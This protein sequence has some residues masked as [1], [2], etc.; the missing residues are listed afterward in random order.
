MANKTVLIA[1]SDGFQGYGDFIFGLKLAKQ[2]D[3]R[4]RAQG[5]VEVDIKLISQDS[6][7]DKVMALGG[8]KEFAVDVI[9]PAEL[10][11]Q[12]AAAKVGVASVIEG[13]VFSK[14]LM[15]QIDD[16]LS[17]CQ[18]VP[19][20]LFTEYARNPTRPAVPHCQRLKHMRYH[21]CVKAGM[22]HMKGEQGLMIE[23][24]DLEAKRDD[25]CMDA[26]D[27]KMRACLISKQA[28]PSDY[29]ASTDLWF[30]YSHDH[31]VRTND[32]MTAAEKYLHLQQAFQPSDA[33]HQDVVMVGKDA[34][35]KMAAIKKLVPMLKDRGFD[36]IAFVNVD[37]KHE[38][39]LHEG[40]GSGS[41]YRVLYS[42]SLSHQTMLALLDLSKD[43]V[44]VT[45][46]QSF[47]EAVS[48][49]KTV[50]YE[51]FNHKKSLN[52]CYRL[53]L[54]ELIE[55]CH[56]SRK[57]DLKLVVDTLLQPCD[58]ESI[59]A[60]SKLLT[61]S[62]RRD[63]RRLNEL[64][65]QQQQSICD[66]MSRYTINP[67]RTV[68]CVK[69]EAGDSALM[70]AIKTNDIDLAM[71]L[72]AQRSTDLRARNVVGDCAFDVALKAGHDQLAISIIKRLQSDVLLLKHPAR[73]Q[74]VLF[75]AIH[76]GRSD[77][78]VAL[79]QICR[80]IASIRNS[81]GHSVRQ[82]AETAGMFDVV[83]AIVGR[84]AS[85]HARIVHALVKKP[86]TTLFKQHKTMDAKAGSN[87]ANAD[88]ST[89][90]LKAA[91]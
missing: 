26:I 2:L 31:A 86:A 63:L 88:Y 28:S 73:Q 17:G 51:C 78:A 79:I 1:V 66:V 81:D 22:E 69:Q 41:C 56:F 82:V 3:A 46:D 84:R 91:H 38:T 29:F 15:S 80:V 25:R 23:S 24:V 34:D 47:S 18:R 16:A 19:L 42:A 50:F 71:T 60:L 13:P 40:S 87:K 89:H 36:R 4:Y 72:I 35:E 77:V 59:A 55:S 9:T 53:R 65:L 7:R 67:L 44:G 43:L 33:K 32:S 75:D 54:H 48:R 45:G 83:N 21:A 14:E 5:L 68:D 12:V 58:A 37:S 20:I 57:A 11:E 64:F 90:G 27:G 52:A 30:Q 76:Y 49:A 74:S 8:H 39:V 70:V 61:H 10:V 62:C 85:K 6:G